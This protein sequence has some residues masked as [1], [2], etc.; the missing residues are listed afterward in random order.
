MPAHL[1][2][3]RDAARGGTPGDLE[4]DRGR[5][6]ERDDVGEL[7]DRRAGGAR[8]GDDVEHAVGHVRREDLGQ[9][10]RAADRV[11]RRLEHDG[12]AVRER[13]R[14]L[15]QRDRER[16]VPRRDQPGDAARAAAAHHQRARV[17][18]R[19]G[20]DTC[21][22][23]GPARP[24]PGSA[25]SARRGRPPARPPSSGLPTSRTISSITSSAA[26]CSASAAAD[27]ASARASAERRPFGL[28]RARAGER[29]GDRVAVG[30]G[31]LDDDVGLI[32]RGAALDRC[33]AHLVLHATP[34]RAPQTSKCGV[35]RTRAARARV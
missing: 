25:G 33:G 8:A 26:A 12:V 29:L 7:D 34:P 11:G 23:R 2:L 4:P 19:G 31:R 35:P 24:A 15:P 1:A 28:R 9:A 20:G 30:G 6:R 5:A 16:E 21:R 13:G 17:R 10:Q 3:R 32:L 27:S 18:G 14:G 22:R